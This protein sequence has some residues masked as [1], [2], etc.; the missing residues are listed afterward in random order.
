MPLV[1]GETLGP[2][3]CA[4]SKGLTPGPLLSTFMH[5]PMSDEED[6]GEISSVTERSNDHDNTTQHFST[7]A[8][9]TMSPTP[10]QALDVL[11]SSL[12]Q[13]VTPASS[14][15]Q[16][17]HSLLSDDDEDGQDSD[18][19][20]EEHAAFPL[21]SADNVRKNFA[22]GIQESHS[23]NCNDGSTSSRDNNRNEDGGSEHSIED[24]GSPECELVGI[25]YATPPRYGQNSSRPDVSGP[26][27]QERKRA[28]SEVL[29]TEQE[30][31]E[32]EAAAILASEKREKRRQQLMDAKRSF[33]D[34][35]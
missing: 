26:S 25:G 29:Q 27:D 1:T 30:L 22:L 4:R 9:P 23:N 20:D 5:C 16:V 33:L 34:L 21:F 6:D 2:P 12:P 11:N 32:E 8:R 10:G 17:V 14:M 35:D 18:D 13:R 24:A 7:S 28:W 19:D 31:D 3:N 15:P